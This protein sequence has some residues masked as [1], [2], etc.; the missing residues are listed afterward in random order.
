MQNKYDI[1]IIGSGVAGFSLATALV[2]KYKHK[3]LLLLNE[4]EQSLVPCG[5]PYIFGKL[6]YDV[7]AD[8]KSSK[9]LIDSGCVFLA[10]KVKSVD[11]D[12][13]CLETAFSSKYYYDKLIFATGS[14]PLIPSF[15]KGYDNPNV[16]Y[17]KKSVKY[18]TELIPVLQKAK[19]IAIV[20]GGFIGLE[21]AE[22][23]ALDKSKQINVIEM[24]N[25]CLSA[26]FSPTFCSKAEEVLKN[27][28][29]VILTNKK[30]TAIEQIGNSTNVVFSDKEELLVDIVIFSLGYK[31]NTSIA[32][33]AGL[34]LNKFGAIDVD[35]FM[36]T[37]DQNIFAIG[38]CAKKRD[39]ATGKDS[40]AMLASVAGAESRFLAENLYRINSVK[41]SLGTIKVFSTSLDGHV[42]ASAGITEAEAE[43]E[44]IS[45]FTGEFRGYDKHPMSLPGTSEVFAR[46]HVMTETAYI[47]GAEISGSVSVGEMINVIGTAIQAR[48][49]IYDLYTFQFG[50][51]PLL[52]GGPAVTPIIKAVENAIE[53]IGSSLSVS[54]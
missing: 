7:N 53:K 51:H 34:V 48:L 46:I 45:I 12:N 11:K 27:N 6:N 15:I 3:S 5:I 10:D 13:K 24:Q 22:Q 43:K 28:G 42:F 1:V 49:T 47:V 40:N 33:S 54:Y 50:T 32:E 18:T 39:F 36:R 26:A 2:K 30:V 37:D 14:S 44:N 35:S 20:G 9:Y 23:L 52:T 17:I 16:Y 29:I 4:E 21:V 31:P 38:D 25:N 41:N 19:K 8:I